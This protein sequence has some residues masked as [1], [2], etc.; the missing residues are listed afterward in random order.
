VRFDPFIVG[1][2]QFVRLRAAATAAT[3]SGA[4]NFNSIASITLSIGADNVGVYIVFFNINR[5]NLWQMIAIELVL[6]A[7]WCATASWFGRPQVILR[8]VDRMGTSW[9]R[10]CSSDLASIFWYVDRLR[11]RLPRLKGRSSQVVLS[12]PIPIS[13]GENRA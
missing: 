11:L 4:Q 9:H 2:T 13:I 12:L 5:T 1:I 10:W 3:I 8:L 7:L 6:L